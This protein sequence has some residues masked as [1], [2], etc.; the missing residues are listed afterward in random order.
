MQTENLNY[1]SPPKLDFG[2]FIKIVGKYVFIY[3]KFYPYAYIFILLDI[4]VHFT[5]RHKLGKQ[6]EA[7]V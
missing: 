4:N 6:L 2:N 7:Y 1:M 5:Q 3:I